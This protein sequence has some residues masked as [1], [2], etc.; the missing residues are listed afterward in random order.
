[1]NAKCTETG[2]LTDVSHTCGRCLA[3]AHGSD[4]ILIQR[5]KR[6][7]PPENSRIRQRVRDKSASNNY[8]FLVGLTIGKSK[9]QDGGGVGASECERGFSANRKTAEGEIPPIHTTR[10][11][12]PQD[13]G[14]TLPPTCVRVGLQ[15]CSVQYNTTQKIK[16]YQKN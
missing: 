13:S 6:V 11:T 7:F 10:D 15:V 14:G 3:L 2:A 16:N 12:K 4:W 5:S 1:M 8:H 9:S